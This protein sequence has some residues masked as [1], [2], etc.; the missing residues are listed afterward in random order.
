MQFYF[1]AMYIMKSIKFIDNTP[2]MSSNIRVPTLMNSVSHKSGIQAQWN[3]PIVPK[4]SCFPRA[5]LSIFIALS[6][7]CFTAKVKVKDW[8]SLDELL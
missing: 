2:I 5:T 7:D 3:L 8:P 6:I 1:H 4:D